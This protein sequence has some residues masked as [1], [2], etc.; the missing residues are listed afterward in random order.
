MTIFLLP[1]GDAAAAPRPG[2]CP[3]CGPVFSH[4]SCRAEISG[5]L[6]S[7]AAAANQSPTAR[8]RP[9]ST[10]VVDHLLF[11]QSSEII[12]LTTGCGRIIA[13]RSG[14]LQPEQKIEIGDYSR[15]VLGHSLSIQ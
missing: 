5:E 10:F 9:A 14:W 7:A 1:E 12:V 15:S 8:S 11:Q 13:G 2:G 3:C 6:F 4:D